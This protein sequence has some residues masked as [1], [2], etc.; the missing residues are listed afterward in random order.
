MYKRQAYGVAFV[1]SLESASRES[2]MTKIAS[3]FKAISARA[4]GGAA[5][6]ALLENDADDARADDDAETSF[7]KKTRRK[8]R[9]KKRMIR[10][11][12]GFLGQ[13]ALLAKRSWRQVRRDGR[14]NRVRLIASLNSAAVFGSIFWK[15]GLGKARFKIGAGCCR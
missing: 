7:S 8:T 13:L 15:L 12:A 10:E 2:F 5:S 9:R 3:P 4:N 14:T 6:L 1:E 11:R